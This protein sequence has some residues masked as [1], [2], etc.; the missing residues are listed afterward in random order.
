[1][2]HKLLTT[3]TVLSSEV[4]GENVAAA[5]AVVDNVVLHN[6][7]VEDVV[8]EDVV[9]EDVAARLFDVSSANWSAPRYCPD[10]YSV[11][12]VKFSVR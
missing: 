3:V 1:M 2:D 10:V 6:G 5:T 7:V 12:P 9:I 4:V 8:I 11:Q